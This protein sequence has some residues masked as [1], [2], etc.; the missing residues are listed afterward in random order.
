MQSHCTAAYLYLWWRVMPGCST[1][2]SR[3][4]HSVN[5]FTNASPKLVSASQ[6]YRRSMG[7]SLAMTS[8][9]VH[10]FTTFLETAD[11]LS[12]VAL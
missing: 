2:C 11:A 6:A 1:R 8:A 10:R 12:P 3:Y 4:R 7:D 5:F 9:H